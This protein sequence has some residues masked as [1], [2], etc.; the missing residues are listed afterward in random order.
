L[1]SA[2]ATLR[3][4]PQTHRSPKE[5]GGGQYCGC[6][7]LSGFLW[8]ICRVAIQQVPEASEDLPRT[9]PKGVRSVKMPKV[10]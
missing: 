1:E 2:A 7:G 3:A 10:K 5:I 8:A 4:V 9:T 6:P